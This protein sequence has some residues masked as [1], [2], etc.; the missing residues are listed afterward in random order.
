M[1]EQSIKKYLLISIGSAFLF[2]AGC[3]T[4]THEHKMPDPAPKEVVTVYDSNGSFDGVPGT[5]VNGNDYLNVRAPEEVEKYYIN[6]Y[7][8]PVTGDRYPGGVAYH[9]T[10][11]PKWNMRPNPDVMPY[12]LEEAYKHIH[13]LSNGTALQ[14]EAENRN[15]TAKEI[16]KTLASQVAVMQNLQKTLQS[17]EEKNFQY[18]KTMELILHQNRELMSKNKELEEKIN[19]IAKINEFQNN[20]VGKPTPETTVPGIDNIK[21]AVSGNTGFIVSGSEF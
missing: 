17:K 19:Q 13:N 10:Q 5:V 14:A 9:I 8:D 4:Y 1:K 11:K 12:E 20:N 2:T 7:P 3:T 21:E 16:N 18:K 15:E 6:P